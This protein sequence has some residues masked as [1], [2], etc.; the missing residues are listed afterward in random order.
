MN[1]IKKVLTII[2]CFSLSFIV[3]GTLNVKA[4]NS[5]NIKVKNA[6]IE[7]TNQGYSSKEGY[8][9][10]VSNKNANI[11]FLTPEYETF[12]DVVVEFRMMMEGDTYDGDFKLYKAEGD[13]IDYGFKGGVWNRVRFISKVYSDGTDK[14]VKLDLFNGKNK[15]ILVSDISILKA[16]EKEKLLGGVKL[17]SMEAKNLMMGYVLVTPKGKVIVVDGGSNAEVDSL[18]KFIRTFTNKVDYWVLTHFHSDHSTAIYTILKN[19]DIKI[20]NLYFDFP[21][22]ADVKSLSGDADGWL[23]DALTETINEYPEKIGN[24]VTPHKGD[25]VEVE[26]GVKIIVLNDA[27]KDQKNNNYGNNS[28]IMYKIS[29]PNESILFTGDMG[30]RGDY[31]LEDE[32]IKKEVESCTIIQMAHHGQNG[33]TDKFYSTIKEIKVALYPAARWIYDN[34]GGKGFN[35]ATL[36]TLHTR[37]LIRERGVIDIYVSAN[38]RAILE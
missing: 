35:T 1:I 24:V 2:I 16:P 8:K 21:S 22:S 15:T 27:W 9:I 34:D 14:Y 7:E 25:I 19:Y 20:D 32:W 30:D 5:M 28:G 18:I 13:L 11:F 38:G 4:E 36:T 3:C 33:V 17:Y 37:D 26:E 10:N 6:T 31:Y 12:S 29:T 23:S